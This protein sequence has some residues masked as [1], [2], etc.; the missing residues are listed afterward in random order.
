MKPQ[1]KYM[2]QRILHGYK[3]FYSDF[4]PIKSNNT[5][6]DGQ[7]ELHTFL[8]N[9]IDIVYDN[10]SVLK[11]PL[12]ADSE[13]FYTN[14]TL[15]KD[16][17]K[18]TKLLYDF[19]SFMYEAGI[20]GSIA[21]DKQFVL[22]LQTLKSNKIVFKPPY[23]DLLSQAGITGIKTKEEVMFTHKNPAIFHAWK[24]LSNVDVSVD[25]EAYYGDFFP[26]K[27][28][29]FALCVFDGKADFL[30]P[31]IEKVMT[32]ENGF[33]NK[34]E[35]KI[36][37]AGFKKGKV[38]GGIGKTGMG[39]GIVYWKE[40]C[41]FGMSSSSGGEINYGSSTNRGFKAMLKDFV[42]LDT[43]IQAYCVKIAK[44]CLG[45]GDCG[46]CNKKGTYHSMI[47]VSFDGEDMILCSDWPSN[48]I[49]MENI[50]FHIKFLSLQNKYATT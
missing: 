36:F 10:P 6:E 21:D 18:I 47:T 16:H 24:L 49:V 5:T 8:R 23:L 48:A 45:A 35:E 3:S 12:V 34:C 1:F 46:V 28:F 29:N 37:A 39:F 30:F 31:K 2:A 41:G 44:K 25:W 40:N 19:Y 22:S 9:I 17:H 4:A 26:A 13:D 7:R 33:L 32:W 11:M 38:S 20:S 42:N 27:L 50:D 15:R 43:D 14:L